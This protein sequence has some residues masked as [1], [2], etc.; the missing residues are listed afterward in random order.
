MFAMLALAPG[1]AREVD[2][3][4]VQLI[5]IA[6]LRAMTDR[7]ARLPDSD[8]VIVIDARPSKYYDE[9]HIPGARNIL[10][11]K[12]DPKGKVDPTIG[13]FATIV[14]YGDDPASPE[15]RALT[16]RLMVIGYSRVRLFAGGLKGDKVG[17]IAYGYPVE[18]KGRETPPT[19]EAAPTASDRTGAR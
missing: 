2:D 12:F 14:V 6:E 11:S 3:S 16:K 5:R 4:K 15:A 1:C 18:G 17:W 10:L 9:A 8:Q 13:R 7:Q 19:P